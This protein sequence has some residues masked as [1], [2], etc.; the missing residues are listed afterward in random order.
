MGFPGA[1]IQLG[2]GPEQIHL[3]ELNNPDPIAGRPQHGGRD[4]HIALNAMALE[5]I[6]DALNKAG[7]IYTMSLSGRRALFCRDPDGNT[8]EII[9]R[10]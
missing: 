6:Q 2:Q 8:I 3:L 9:E 4:R 10:A 5:P 7:I 1:W